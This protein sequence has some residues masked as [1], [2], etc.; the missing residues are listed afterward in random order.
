MP[1]PVDPYNFSAGTTADADQVDARFA[2]LYSVLNNGLDESNILRVTPTEIAVPSA[3]RSTVN[4]GNY[5]AAVSAVI[6]L[7][8][9]DWATSFD[10]SVANT[11]KVVTPGVYSVVGQGFNN[12]NGIGRFEVWRNGAVIAGNRGANVN[13]QTS[14]AWLGRLAANDLLTLVFVNDG[15]VSGWLTASLTAAWVAA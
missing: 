9:L 10:G 11:L 15:G 6:P 14:V 4:Q 5:A 3:R 13:A 12:G 2:P 8:V 7:E 1:V